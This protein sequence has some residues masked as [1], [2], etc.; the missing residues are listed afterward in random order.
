MR[1][2]LTRALALL[3][4]AALL[5][6][7]LLPGT[8]SG[9]VDPASDVLLLQNVFLPYK[10]K[11]CKQVA[12]ALKKL[13]E[14]ARQAGYPVKVAVIG[15]KFDLGGAPQFFGNPQAY[16]KFLGDELA[17][18]GPGVGKEDLATRP[19]LVV[20]P[21]G[22]G[23]YRG[24]TRAAALLKTTP[25]PSGKDPDQLARAAFNAIPKLAG[26]EGHPV[27]PVKLS[28]GCST[29][30]SSTTLIL[31][32]AP[33]VLLVGAGL[34]LRGLRGR[35]EPDEEHEDESETAGEERDATT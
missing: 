6:G 12:D 33:I 8:A 26:A 29:G 31:I 32:F 9:D 20:M 25:K 7:V 2:P 30:G 18:F 10:P 22:Y 23:L 34:V 5:P 27:K 28:S 35:S 24:G 3:A 1:L 21:Q 16:A 4:A 15:S 13:T 17:V 19:L 11:T 14:N